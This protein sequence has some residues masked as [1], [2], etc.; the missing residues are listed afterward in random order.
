MRN[1]MGVTGPAGEGTLSPNMRS[2]EAATKVTA[3]IA[4]LLYLAVAVTGGFSMLYVPSLIV[5]GNAAA[6]AE[7]LAA[8]ESMFRL[9]I[10]SGLLC[11]VAFLFLA[12]ALY[13]LFRGVDET[14]ASAMVALVVAAVPVAFLNMLN[15]LAALHVL[16]AP[17]HLGAFEKDQLDALMMLFLDLYGLGLLIVEIFWGLWLVPLALLILRSRFV[18]AFLGVLLIV[19]FAGYV[20]DVLA[21]LLFPSHAAA[22]ASIAGASKFGEVVLILWLLVKGVNTPPADA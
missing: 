13:R 21:R 10:V 2:P 19:A 20:A 14:H 4:G 7:A 18:P 5:P 17:A 12:L 16:T 8:H 6:T 11:Q 3:R 15:Q 1:A 22:V 9:G